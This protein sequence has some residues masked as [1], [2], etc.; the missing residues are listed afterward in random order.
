MSEDAQDDLILRHLDGETSGAE[1]AR[2]TRLLAEDAAFRSRFFYVASLITDLQEAGS[3]A[4]REASRTL[5]NGSIQAML[6]VKTPR[7]AGQLADLNIDPSRLLQNA[8]MGG[9]GGLLGWLVYAFADLLLG[10]D[11]RNVY[12]VDAVKGLL[13]GVCI[14]FAV[15][16]TEGLLGSRSLP[17]AV[18]GGCFGAVLGA[19]GGVIG[20]LLGEMIFIWAKGGVWPRA[21][22]WGIFGMFVG[23]SEGV[24]WK[25][26]VKIR[27]GIL[28][29]L[30]GGL[31]GGST[32]DGLVATV[33]GMGF[34]NEALAWGS[35]IGLII[36]GA[37]IGFMVSL[38][39]TLLRK[40]WVFFLTG[41]LEGQ[42]RTLDSSRPHTIGSD[43]SCTIVIPSDPSVAAVHAEIAYDSDNFVIN[44]R[45]GQVVVRRDGVDQPGTSHV[46]VPGDRVILGETRMIFRNVEGK[47]S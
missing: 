1:I 28:G 42:T 43:P 25:M 14:G 24:A 17:R 16:S 45:D 3:L 8:L 35:A 15:G 23:V 40:A 18:R 33:R 30:L 34:R 44:A 26:P 10:I 27:Y 20:L 12:F 46:L 36:L 38:V 19:V 13:F 47:R 21:I 7:A 11:G 39:E 9:F 4:M 6:A 37:C 2:I 29:G 41:R 22:G 32:Y 5:H 31:V